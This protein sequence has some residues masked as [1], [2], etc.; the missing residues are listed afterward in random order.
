VLARPLSRPPVRLDHQL[1]GRARLVVAIAA[2]TGGP[3]ALAEVVPR[4]PAGREAAVV[5]VQ[6]MPRG[7]TRSLAE[8][9]A[10]QSRI[11]VVEAEDRT[12][13]LRDTAY[14]A[15]GEWHLRVE[16]GRDG[17]RLRLAQDPPVWGVRPAADPLF[18][19]VAAAFGPRAI[20][21]VLTGL[22]K[23]GA[24]GL[25]AIHDAGGFG[26]AQDRATA[27]IHGM[28]AAAQAAGG[29]DTV[30]PLDQIAE[31]VTRQLELRLTLGAGAAS[32]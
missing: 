5:I 20:G 24:D 13:L 16:I 18:H 32:P 3:R 9:L 26:I 7:F 1:P 25:R 11:A 21:V 2:S 29:A 4:L 14:V 19:S 12:P 27:A 8:R 17:P 28:P 23:D 30:L 22:G 10:A 6:H 15:P 31:A